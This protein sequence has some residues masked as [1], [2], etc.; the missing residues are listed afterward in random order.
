MEHEERIL[1]LMG[2]AVAGTFTLE[3]LCEL[4]AYSALDPSI[5]LLIRAELARK[6]QGWTSYK[7]G[8]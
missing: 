5:D 8:I 3:E 7:T 1:I 2:K 6:S 4:M